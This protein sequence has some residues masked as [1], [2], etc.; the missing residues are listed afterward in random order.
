[1]SFGNCN[2]SSLSVPSTLVL[3]LI[4]KLDIG[5]QQEVDT[6]TQQELSF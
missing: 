1:M 5:A 3:S 6:E 2:P 4:A